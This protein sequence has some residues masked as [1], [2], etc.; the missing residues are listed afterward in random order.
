[1]RIAMDELQILSQRVGEALQSRGL[2]LA[3]AESCTGG[4]L[5]KAITEVAGSS[6]WFDRGFVTYSDAAKHDLLGVPRETVESAG[7]VSQPTVLAM[8]AGTLTHS[9]AQVAVAIS[10]VAG[11]TGG[12]PDKPVGTVWI[13]WAR[14]DAHPRAT[15]F[16]FTGD[17]EAVRRQSVAAALEGLLH[18]IEL[19]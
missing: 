6:G 5:A 17:R 12:T 2:R 10:G 13:A 4:W 18:E 19:A 8:A 14:S 15:R 9:D 11:P 16:L 1:M 7:A 3:C